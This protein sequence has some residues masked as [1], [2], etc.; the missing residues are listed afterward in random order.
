M[1]ILVHVPSDQNNLHFQA[2]FDK[3]NINIIKAIL[4]TSTSKFLN[5]SGVIEVCTKLSNLCTSA[6][7]YI[8]DITIRVFFNF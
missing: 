5:I 8:T 7:L 2:M 3:T 4:S 1:R 6:T